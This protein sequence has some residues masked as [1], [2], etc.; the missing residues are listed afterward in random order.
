MKHI[1]L[2]KAIFLFPT[3]LINLETDQEYCCKS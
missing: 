3:S 2:E 1:Y